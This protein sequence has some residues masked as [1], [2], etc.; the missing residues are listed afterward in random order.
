MEK[1]YSMPCLYGACFYYKKNSACSYVNKKG[2]ASLISEKNKTS[3]IPHNIIFLRGLEYLIFGLYYFIKNLIKLP[4]DYSNKSLT[5]KISSCLN[6]KH[7]YVWFVIIC[8]LALLISFVLIGF[9]PVKLAL[10]ISGYSSSVF[11]NRLI[12]GVVKVAIIYAIM[13]ILK[14]LIPFKQFYRFNG[15]SN[16]LLNENKSIHIPTNFINYVVFSF[17]FIFFILS[18]IGLTSNQIWKP[19]VNLTISLFCF[20]I[21]YE[22]LYLMEI[23]KFK[24]V[25][26]LCIITSFL[27]TERPT[28]TEIYISLSAYNEVVFMQNKQRGTLDTKMFNDNEIAFSSVYAECK[29]KLKNSNIDDVS[30][31]DWLICEVL[32][33]SRGQIRL[34]KKVTLEQKNAI[35]SAINKRIKGQP[36][37]KIFGRTNFYGM[38]FKVTKDVLS[39]RMET[40]ILV[41]QVL[42]FA[43]DKMNI[44]DLCTGSGVIAVCLAKNTKSNI[45]ATDI[46]EKALSVA[47]ENAEINNVKV[48]FKESNLFNDLKKSKKFDIIVSNPPYVPTLDIEKLDKEVKDYDPKIALDGGKDGLDFYRKIIKQSV[49]YLTKNGMIFFEL[50]IGQSKDVSNMLKEDFEDIKIVK[51]Y[52]RI[53]RVIYAK[54]KNKRNKNVRTNTKN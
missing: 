22:I 38:T 18:L 29:E 42:K 50:G 54:L 34:Q 9:L 19:F 24:W 31:A 45:F 1:I 13:L 2:K 11:L 26:N 6:V 48:N 51:D 44:L 7:S 28:K 5:K 17:C 43:S 46:S 39:P 8:I 20:S 14:L 33:I 25:Y 37:T 36:I 16:Y 27:V 53:N 41:E 23:S 3:I 30:E 21:C 15:C 40:E 47:M 12:V 52:N 35:D 10:L 32:N 4:Y 49:N